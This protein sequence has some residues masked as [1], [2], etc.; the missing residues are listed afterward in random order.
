MGLDDIKF[1]NDDDRRKYLSDLA[2]LKKIREEEKITK[3]RLRSYMN[4]SEYKSSKYEEEGIE[5]PSF[6]GRNNKNTHSNNYYYDEDLEDYAGEDYD[7]QYY[8][9]DYEDEYKEV[10]IKQFTNRR[11]DK[12]KQKTRD[13]DDIMNISKSNTKKNTKNKAGTGKKKKKRIGVILFQLLALAILGFCIYIAF[14]FLNTKDSGYYNVAIFGV[15]SRDGNVKKN[16]LADVN[17]IASINR[18]TGEIK[19]V[20]VYRDSYTEID[21]K[22]TFHKLNEAYFKGGPEQAVAALE[23]NLDI[24]IDDYATFNWKAV[25]ETINILGGVDLEITEP[26]FKYINGFITE[27]VNSTGIGSVQLKAPGMQHL[28]GVQAVAYAR[29]RLM[30]TDFNRTQRQRKVVT[31]AFEKAKNTD[32]MT[33]N[34]IISTVLPQIS[35]SVGL[36]NIIPLAKNINKYHLGQTTGFPFEKETKVV[37]K[38]DYVIVVSL[39]NNVIALHKFLYGEDVN[40]TPSSALNTLSKQIIKNTGIGANAEENIEVKSDDT[41]SKGYIGNKESKASTKNKESIQEESTTSKESITSSKETSIESKESKTNETTKERI[42]ETETDIL[43]VEENDDW[44]ME[45]TA[46]HKSNNDDIGNGPAF[47]NTTET[48][49]KENTNVEQGPGVNN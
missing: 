18:A 38:R 44:N 9:E 12:A 39:R 8:D 7:N 20:S 42:I 6:I 36:N 40:Y 37:N 22:G 32:F 41:N 31:L 3:E 13:K 10:R 29:L 46:S 4:A 47:N 35:T 33:L 1:D 27:T 25:I 45:T 28:D 43:D 49:K 5:I 17:M 2:R 24:K 48:N 34:H 23:R 21:G 30:D 14:L 19:L 15:D 26:E 16:A 11:A